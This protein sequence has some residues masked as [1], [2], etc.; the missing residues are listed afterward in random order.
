MTGLHLVKHVNQAKLSLIASRVSWKK[1]SWLK[2]YIW[3]WSSQR[4]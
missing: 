1:T 3:I 4:I 2:N